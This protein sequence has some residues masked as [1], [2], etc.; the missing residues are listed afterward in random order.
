MRFKNSDG[1]I[2]QFIGDG[3]DIELTTNGPTYKKTWAYRRIPSGKELV[4]LACNLEG[5]AFSVLRFAVW[6]PILEPEPFTLKPLYCA[7]W[8]P[9]LTK[10]H[11]FGANYVQIT[12]MYPKQEDF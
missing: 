1:I 6:E 9:N 3:P 7:R 5:D 4:G 11:M 8:N 2:L 10:H 12:G